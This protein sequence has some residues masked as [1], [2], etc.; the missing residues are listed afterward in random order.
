MKSY[1]QLIRIEQ[2]AKNGLIFLPLLFSAPED[3]YA[4]PLLVLGFFG[5]CSISSVTY[6]INDWVDRAADRLHPTKKNR[7]LASGRLTG[8]TA[9]GVAVFLFLMAGL[10]AWRL[11][12]FY[13][14]LIGFYFLMTNG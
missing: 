2:W 9:L 3:V 12:L 5:F 13:G 4:W 10:V 6:I 14:S 7:P 8:R 11:G 1:V